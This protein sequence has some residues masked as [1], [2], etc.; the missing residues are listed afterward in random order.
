MKK[1]MGQ[2][3]KPPSKFADG[4]M[5]IKI[6]D[7]RGQDTI[8]RWLYDD[9]KDLE[10][11]CQRHQGREYTLPMWK[12][13]HGTY[14]GK[15]RNPEGRSLLRSIY[16]AWVTK[17]GLEAIE[18]IGAERDL[19]GLPII[20]LPTGASAEDRDY[21]EELGKNIRLDDQLSI[22]APAPPVGAEHPWKIELL[23]AGGRKAYD[24][25][26]TIDA[27]ITII[28]MR[29]FAQFLKLGMDKVGTQA[30][31]SGAQDFFSLGLLAVQQEMLEMW[32]LKLVPYLFNLN[33]WPGIT[34][35]PE[36]EWAPPGK[37]DIKQVI[38]NLER[39]TKAQIVTPHEGLEDWV[40][41][42]AGLPERPEDV[43][44]GERTPP[45]TDTMDFLLRQMRD[46]D[47]ADMLDGVSDKL[48]VIVEQ[49]AGIALAQ[50]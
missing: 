4:K 34:G 36:I 23:S 45:A 38:E 35:L 8:Y 30:L 37:S 1:R 48:D 28:L 18:R 3:G 42:Q 44:V 13:L 6:L 33:P 29:F 24:I 27:Y 46:M 31:V 32:N 11:V 19:A 12:L 9:D 47:R 20:Y 41:E 39:L 17:D 7:P 50:E 49:V 10:A 25:R 15:K 2:T 40:L 16:R 43:G 21:A 26:K 14:G 22:V 5:G